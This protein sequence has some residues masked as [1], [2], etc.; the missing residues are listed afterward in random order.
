[1]KDK[2]YETIIMKLVHN[3]HFEKVIITSVDNKRKA[4]IHDI[5]ELFRQYGDIAAD[6]CQHIGEAMEQAVAYQKQLKGAAIYCVGSLYL[7][8]GVKK[9]IGEYND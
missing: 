5:A 9:W 1:V 2:D 6:T 8:G 7:V 4:P 3:I